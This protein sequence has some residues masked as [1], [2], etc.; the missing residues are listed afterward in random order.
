MVLKEDDAVVGELACGGGIVV[1]VLV[2]LQTLH[3]VCAVIGVL[4]CVYSIYYHYLKSKKTASFVKICSITVTI[5]WSITAVGWGINFQAACFHESYIMDTITEQ[6]SGYSMTFGYSLLYLSFVFRVFNAFN[7]SMFAMTKCQTRLLYS[8][9]LILICLSLLTG[10]FFLLNLFSLGAMSIALLY[11]CY[12]IFSIVLVKILISKMTIYFLLKNANFDSNS[13]N[14][15]NN[16]NIDQITSTKSISTSNGARDN[17]N[18]SDIELQM[19]Q[20]QTSQTTE[21]SETSDDQTS[22]TSSMRD[23]VKVNNKSYNSRSFELLVKLT[24]IYT[25]A[26][27]STL[28]VMLWNTFLS[29]LYG[30]D[31]ISLANV[32]VTQ[33][34]LLYALDALVNMLCLLLQSE[35]SQALY[36]KICLKCHVCMKNACVQR[37][38]RLLGK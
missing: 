22:Q 37:S 30:S 26:L 9:T 14:N 12:V 10:V 18:T 17:I 29:I 24:V 33:V 35:N 36:Q 32:V 7:G 31:N 15:T 23:I 4:I 19:S 8:F 13:N 6:I 16:N 1:W 5:L 25:T 20:T 28:I 11:L 2:L 34:R 27:L 38:Q 3:Y 21:K